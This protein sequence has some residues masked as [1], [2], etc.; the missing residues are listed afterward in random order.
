[1]NRFSNMHIVEI[2]EHLAHA[3]NMGWE[4]FDDLVIEILQ[5]VVDHLYIEKFEADVAKRREK[6]K[7]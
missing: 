5:R 4:D 2:R 1:M 7:I 6:D 3:K